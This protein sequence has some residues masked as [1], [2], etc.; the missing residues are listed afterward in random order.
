MLIFVFMSNINNSS[1]VFAS[2]LRLQNYSLIVKE[3]Q[4]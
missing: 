1:E 2:V 3:S 4:L